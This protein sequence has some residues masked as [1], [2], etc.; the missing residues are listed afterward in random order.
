MLVRF[1]FKIR[2]LFLYHISTFRSI[3]IQVRFNIIR[4]L[5]YH[6]YEVLINY[7]KIVI[8]LP[9]EILPFAKVYVE[10]KKN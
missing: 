5:K 10:K 8:I 1:F 6:S 7:I 4:R 9:F 3:V 2:R